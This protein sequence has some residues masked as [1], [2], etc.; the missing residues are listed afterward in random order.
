MKTYIPNFLPLKLMSDAAPAI[1]NGFSK[2]YPGILP[3]KCF[4]H[5]MKVFE[6]RKY[7]DPAVKSLFLGDLF[8]LSK[9]HNQ[10]HFD[11]SE[12]LFLTKYENHPDDSIQRAV[13][14]L[15]K[16][17]LTSCNR[18]WHSG[19]L[20]GSVT[21]NNGLEVTNRIFKKDFKGMKLVQ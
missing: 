20:P 7:N 4:F 11:A 21:S 14:H 16:I 15:I 3:G 18:G 2:V 9:S 19:L 13:E 8:S 10:T 6:D 17:W 1:F 5:M 12:R